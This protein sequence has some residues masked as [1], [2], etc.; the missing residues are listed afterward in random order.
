[1]TIPFVAA[2]LLSLCAAVMTRMLHRP[3]L[4]TVCLPR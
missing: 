4:P 2:G 3:G 1:L